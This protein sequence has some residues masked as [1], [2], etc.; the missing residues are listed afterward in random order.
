MAYSPESFDLALFGLHLPIR[1]SLVST[2]GYHLFDEIPA[3]YIDDMVSMA[4][5]LL[6]EQFEDSAV[7]NSFV[8]IFVNPI[9]ECELVA[10]QLMKC[11]DLDTITGDRLDIAGVI[12]GVSRN[13]LS[14]EEYRTLL[15]LW[16]YL[17]KSSGEPELLITALR[18]F[19]KTSSIH[20]AESHP[21]KVL[22]EFHSPFQP[23][24]NLRAMLQK[25]AVGGV[26]ILLS[27]SN[28]E[29]ADFGFDGEGAYP[30]EATT[31]GFT[32]EDYVPVVG[33]KFVEE[34]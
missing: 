22:L 30:P 20:Y 33:G 15:K 16:T 7:I 23:P 12:L 4:Q 19:A 13:G 31:D 21:A 11:R 3:D 17:N 28:D 25:L 34:I 8:E 29:D 18:T 26:K 10:S 2:F 27:W 24:S 14:D 1:S 32:E 9:Q 5:G 6:I